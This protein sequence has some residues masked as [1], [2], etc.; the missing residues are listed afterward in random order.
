M[1]KYVYALIKNKEK[2]L[3]LKRPNTK[4]SYGGYWNLAGGKNEKNETEPDT[5]VR[6]VKEE[7]RLDFVPLIKVMDLI[8][9][10]TEPK[11]VI[12]FIGGAKGVIKINDEHEEYGWFNIEE[13]KNIPIMPYLKKLFYG[14]H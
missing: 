7:T 14:E 6:E 13:I 11:K 3:L 1:K 10:N 4:K 5:V 9:K 12:V 2:I 8:D